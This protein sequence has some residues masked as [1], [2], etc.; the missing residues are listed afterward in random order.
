M[1]NTIGHEKAVNTL[2][3]GLQSGRVSHAYLI[4]GPR[5]VG[6]MTL[7]QDLARAVNCTEDDRPCD[8]CNQCQ[9]ISDGLHADVRIIGLET[10]DGGEGRA[11]MNITIDQMR[12]AQRDASLRPY[13]GLFRVFIVDGAELLSE[14]AANSLLKTLEEPPDQVIFVLLATDLD[15]I[16]PT[17]I[18][19][20]TRL[21]LRPLPLESVSGEIETNHGVEHQEAVEIARISR[22][23]VGWAIRAARD[24]ELMKRRT[25]NL[26]VIEETVRSGL[27]GRFSYCERMAARFTQN[28]ESVYQELDL[29]LDWWRDVLVIREGVPDIANNL[30]RIDSLKAIASSL[31]S[32]QV[33]RAIKAAQETR[34]YLER[35][36]NPRLA[37]EQFMLSVP[38]VSVTQN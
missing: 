21:D 35:N 10:L 4:T 32:G 18:S 19:R 2:K 8:R 22:G 17:I 9:R 29:W 12:Q 15:R 5:N 30:S 36:V 14:E 26:Q 3:R 31:D 6:K 23:R 7:A 27:E 20:C 25:E 37:L 11:R 33:V 24:P 16:L 1:W 28:R 34:K 38:K 13:E